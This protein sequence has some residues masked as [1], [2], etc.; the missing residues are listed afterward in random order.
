M[1]GH[2]QS[3]QQLGTTNSDR[4]RL[5]LEKISARQPSVALV[6]QKDGRSVASDPAYHASGARQKTGYLALALCGNRSHPRGRRFGRATTG[7]A[8]CDL[9]IDPLRLRAPL[10]PG[11]GDGQS[12]IRLASF[13]PAKSVNPSPRLSVF[14][15][16][17]L[18]QAV[19]EL[20][21]ISPSFDSGG[22]PGGSGEPNISVWW[23][24]GRTSSGECR[25]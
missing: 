19:T 17:G 22:S 3:R 4:D 20:P 6:C 8:Q 9:D 15:H 10:G 23:V 7:R 1:P 12:R 21:D 25:I 14:V 11:R 5:V 18:W 16:A 2:L 24:F 13:A